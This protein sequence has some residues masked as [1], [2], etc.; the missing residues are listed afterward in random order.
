MEIEKGKIL[1]FRGSWSSGLGSLVIQDS[2]SEEV[3]S[4]FC[5]NGATVR[6]LEGCF[7]N[8]IAEGHTVAQGEDA[9]YYNQEV[10]YSCDSI[11][12]L[13]AFTPV[14]EAPEELV[15]AYEAQEEV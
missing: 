7:G 2:I 13:E 14:E 4:I 9:G 15:E 10:F 3:T 5:E 11:G 12:I 6:A 1:A 8:V